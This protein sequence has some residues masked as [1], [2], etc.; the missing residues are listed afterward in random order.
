MVVSVCQQ[1]FVCMSAVVCVLRARHTFSFKKNGGTSLVVES[2]F[3]KIRLHSKF[4][5]C[6]KKLAAHLRVCR[7][8]TTHKPKMQRTPHSKQPRHSFISATLHRPV[9][10]TALWLDLCCD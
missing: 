2:L 7:K 10:R 1:L 4:G 6:A 9:M 5:G 8:G 3:V